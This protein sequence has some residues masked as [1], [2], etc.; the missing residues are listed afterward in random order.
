LVP[1]STVILTRQKG[2]ELQVYLVKRSP[3]SGFMPGNYVFPG[4]MLDP[5][6]RDSEMWKAHV[7]MDTEEISHRFGGYLIVEDA[8]ATGI[9]AI[10]ETFEEA[11][12]FLGFNG[13]QTKRELKRFYEM[14]RAG[15]LTKGWLREY[16]MAAEWV[17]SLS[18]LARWSHWITPK[19]RSKRFDAR[20]FVAFMPEDQ[21]CTPDYRE[22]TH[23]IWISPEHGLEENLRGNIP[24]SPPTVVTLTELLKYPKPNDLRKEVKTRAWGKV[25][26]PRLID[27]PQG[28]LILLPWDPVYDRD[29]VID[30]GE[31]KTTFL[32]P[33]VPFSRILYHEGLWRPVGN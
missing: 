3:L 31:L 23:G 28:A 27:L 19:E 13:E 25:R 30:T 20:F 12:V 2:G 16:V 21:E 14:R 33:G 11:G 18:G 22:I 9:A 26:E 7:D 5:E 6:D 1:A 8:L 10:R 32:R 17:L 29:G 24:L 15:H 4:G